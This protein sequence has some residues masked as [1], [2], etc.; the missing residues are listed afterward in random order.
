MV[1]HNLFYSSGL[2]YVFGS[3]ASY[4][5]VNFTI[6]KQYLLRRAIYGT[7][8]WRKKIAFSKQYHFQH[9]CYGTLDAQWNIDAGEMCSTRIR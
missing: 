4:P 1:D 7:S 9:Q 2:F 8:G 6:Q 3:N 5:S